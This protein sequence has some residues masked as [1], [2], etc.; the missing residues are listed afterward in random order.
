M[1]NVK[2]IGFGCESI[3]SVSGDY[4]EHTYVDR[5]EFAKQVTDALIAHQ[6]AFVSGVSKSGKTLLVRHT[7][8]YN[9][10][11]YIWLRGSE[12][13]SENHFWDLIFTQLEIQSSKKN[14]SK[15]QMLTLEKLVEKSICIV[16]DDFHYVPSYDIRIN[17]LRILKIFNEEGVPIILVAVQS[18]QAREVELMPDMNAR[19]VHIPLSSWDIDELT[20]IASKGFTSQGTAVMQLSRLAQE[21]F[22]SPFLM[23]LLCQMY[24]RLLVKKYPNSKIAYIEKVDREDLN[25]ILPNAASSVSYLTTYAML[26]NPKVCATDKLFQR[27]DG[28]RGNLNQMILYAIAGKY[29]VGAMPYL[30]VH[31]SRLMQRLMESLDSADAVL[32]NDLY[33]ESLTRMVEE[34]RFYY[35]KTYA[36]DEVRHDPIIDL[37]GQMFYVRDPFFLF[38]LRHTTEI[39]KQFI[40]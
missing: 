16:V 6:I 18:P 23:Q 13:K 8:S 36:N 2:S 11:S 17:L 28:K 22:G 39:E 10:I 4:P 7:L 14:R 12:I 40:S 35:E 19:I 38:Y 30:E 26:T 9:K 21:S 24:C 15:F 33:Y 20:R 27:H 25:A 34:Y 31:V 32:S 3:F 29:P 1:S 5:R 37:I